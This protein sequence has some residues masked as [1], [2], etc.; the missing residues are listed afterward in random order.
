M[1]EYLIGFLAVI[2]LAG[3]VLSSA[4]YMI[5]GRRNKIIRRL[6]GAFI[7]AST[8]NLVSVFLNNWSPYF[9]LLLPALFGG[10]SMGYGADIGYVKFIRRLLYAIAICGSGLI[11]C[12]VLGGASWLILPLHV[13]VGLWSIW[14]GVKSI[15]PA[16]AEE[17][18]I[19]ALLNLGLVMYPFTMIFYK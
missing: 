14:L 18:F 13:S 9:L 16:A 6:G 15:V 11:M 5:G 19:C 12:L 4:S 8:V 1:S 17:V 2:S 10:F 3:V 7:L